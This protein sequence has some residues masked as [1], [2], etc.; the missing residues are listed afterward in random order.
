MREFAAAE[1]VYAFEVHAVREGL[2]ARLAA[3]R[4]LSSEHQP[5]IE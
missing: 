2:A 3:E 4:D 1:I 5:L